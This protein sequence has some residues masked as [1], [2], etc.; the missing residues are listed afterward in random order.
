MTHPVV[1]HCLVGAI[2]ALA[3]TLP[4][5]QS[6]R[7]SPEGLRLL[8][9]YEGCSLQPYQ[10]S[11]G[12]WTDGIGNT[13][14]VIPGKD[15]TERQAAKGLMTNVQ[16]V[17]QRLENCVLPAVPQQVYDALVSFAFNV[18]T[19]SA[20]RSTLVRLI[21]QQ[22]WEEACRQLPRWIYVKGVIN[23]GL[24]NRRLREMAWCL[25]GTEQ[26]KKRE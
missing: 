7:T 13:S 19:T 8:A 18:G 26:E 4:E 2:L 20:C 5:F 1:K 22:R 24:K 10:C 9:D 21:N 17:E 14:G 11:A 12:V 15:I 23:E 3:A 6:L 25:K 16:R